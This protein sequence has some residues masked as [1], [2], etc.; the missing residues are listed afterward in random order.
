MLPQPLAAIE[1]E[2]EVRLPVWEDEP[3]S[4]IPSRPGYRNLIQQWEREQKE[5]AP[6]SD[7]V[8]FVGSS[9]IRFW[10]RLQEDFAE[11]DV[12]QR[13][14]G[15]AQLWEV[16][17]YV[18]QLVVANK[19]KAIVLFAGTNDIAMGKSIE[20]TYDAYRCFVSRVHSSLGPMPIFFIGITPTPAR[21]DSWGAASKVNQSIQKLSQDWSGLHYIDI[22]E[23]FLRLGTPPSSTIFLNDGLHLN[24]I[25]Y[26]MWTT[27]IQPQLKEVV[28]KSKRPA[29]SLKEGDSILFD[30]GPSNLDDGAHAAVDSFGQHWNHWYDVQGGDVIS[31]GSQRTLVTTK[32][33]PSTARLVLSGAFRSNGILHGG[34]RKPPKK[35]G[36]M[37]V[38]RATQDYFYTKRGEAEGGFSITGLPPNTQHHVRIVAHRRGVPQRITQYRIRGSKEHFREIHTTSRRHSNSYQTNLSLR[39]DAFGKIHV[40]M[41]IKKGDYAY[42]SAFELRVEK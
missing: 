6:Y 12:T 30:F 1:V 34:L 25:G 31:A 32:G 29:S 33:A 17:H 13:G 16:A 26:T 7:G 5:T 35:L 24:G 22:P 42:I 23:V 4:K 39:S 8:L 41:R 18:P 37:A 27:I 3:C 36:N 28:A 20:Q 9:S 19:P 38:S 21:W 10:K 15:G 14:F 11:W 40:D 2:S